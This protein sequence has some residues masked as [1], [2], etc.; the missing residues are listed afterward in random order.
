MQVQEL[1]NTATAEEVV[2]VLKRDGCV[3]VRELGVHSLMDTIYEELKP[4][5]A[6][7]KVGRDDFAGF[8]TTRTGS[9]I[10]RSPSFHQLAMHPLIL[11][12]AAKILGPYCQKFQL[13]LTQ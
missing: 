7:T 8:H 6:A 3:I 11:N 12:T 2:E 10:A 1:K 9:L 13:H 5:I 4:F